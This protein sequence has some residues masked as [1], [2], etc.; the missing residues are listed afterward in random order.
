MN[1]AKIARDIARCQSQLLIMA[2]EKTEQLYLATIPSEL[3]DVRRG[4]RV[5]AS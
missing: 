5:K 1:P 3:P 2:K 4:I